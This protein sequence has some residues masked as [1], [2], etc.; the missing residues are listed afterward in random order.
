MKILR[1]VGAVVV[2]YLLFAVA[3][4]LLISLLAARSGFLLTVLALAALGVCAAVR[5]EFGFRA[6]LRTSAKDFG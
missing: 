4:M 6:D 3:S 5:G 2:G 1:T